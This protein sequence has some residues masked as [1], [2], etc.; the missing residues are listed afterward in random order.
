MGAP[1][2]G[3]RPVALVLRI[4]GALGAVLVVAGLTIS[5]AQGSAGWLHGSDGGPLG[6]DPLGG[7]AA[8]RLSDLRGGL[9]HG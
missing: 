2:T 6:G 4:G 7:G 1:E 8:M 9:R 5:V 3:A